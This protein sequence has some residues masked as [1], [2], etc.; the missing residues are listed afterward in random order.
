MTRLLQSIHPH[1]RVARLRISHVD[2]GDHWM[3][4]DYLFAD[5]ETLAA[6]YQKYQEL[7]ARFA[8]AS[9]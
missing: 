2:R 5:D 1:L 8:G 6:D 7:K 4:I 9:Q 3:P